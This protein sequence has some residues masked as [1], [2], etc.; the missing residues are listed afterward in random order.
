MD[1]GTPESPAQESPSGTWRDF[2]APLILVAIVLLGA[3]LRVYRI[4]DE[5]VWVD[6]S[7][8]YPQLHQPTL[9]AYLAAIRVQDPPM[10]PLY[11]TLQYYWARTVGDSVVAVRMLSVLLGVA[12]LPLLYLLGAQ[13]YNRSAGLI[14]ALCAALAIPHV[15]YAQEIRTYALVLLLSVTSMY[16][17][18]RALRGSP[19]WWP[20]HALCNALLLATHIFGVLLLFVQALFLLATHAKR[21]KTLLMWAAVHAAMLVPYALYLNSLRGEALSHSI[22]MIPIPSLRWLLNTYCVY[23]TGLE[24]WGGRL[25]DGYGPVYAVAALMLVALV[26]CFI[27]TRKQELLTSRREAFVLLSLWYLVPPLVLYVVSFCVTPCF[28]ERYALS[29]SF[30]LYLLAGGVFTLFNRPWWTAAVLCALGAAYT[31]AHMDTERPYRLDYR[32]AALVLQASARADEP[33]IGWKEVGES[34]LQPYLAAP[35]KDRF[36]HV[37]TNEEL[38]REVDARVRP[39]STCWAMVYDGPA[40]DPRSDIEAQLRAKGLRF[41][42]TSLAGL[43]RLHIYQITRD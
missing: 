13:L 15:Y 31:I 20:L 43:R 26:A 30:A 23:Y 16:F 1:M 27:G 9:G 29:S 12:T 18:L 10:S 2:V 33:V 7:V 39:G 41:H 28:V 5:S 11:F 36:T 3:A 38:L 42:R 4:A 40:G 25:P 37:E 8:S 17:L 14:A 34:L 32:K 22:S 19:G 21:W 6:E 24:P 35:L